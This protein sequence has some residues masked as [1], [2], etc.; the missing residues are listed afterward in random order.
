MVNENWT[1]YLLT[2]TFMSFG[3]GQ[4]TDPQNLKSIT[5]ISLFPWLKESFGLPIVKILL[6][7][8]QSEEDQDDD[9]Y[10]E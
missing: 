2:Y 5:G 3:Q 1:Q 4:V 10:Y 6:N 9:D 8:F 7:Q